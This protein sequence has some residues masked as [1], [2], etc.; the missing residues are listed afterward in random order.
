V[1]RTLGGVDAAAVDGRGGHV[2]AAAAVV[3]GGGVAA[4]AVAAAVDV[5]VVVVTWQ[6]CHVVVAS[7]W[8]WW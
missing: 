2:P 1:S 8:R 3:A 7:R 4:A 6:G 5:P